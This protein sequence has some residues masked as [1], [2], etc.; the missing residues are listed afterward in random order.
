[1]IAVDTNILVC[2]RREDLPWHNEAEA[3][4]RELAEGLAQWTIP[5]PCLHEFTAIVTPPRIDRPPTPLGLALDQAEAWQ[6]SPSLVILAEA[7]DHWSKLKSLALA[8][9]IAGPQ[10][11]DACIAAL[12]ICHGA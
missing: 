10:I 8:G 9:K 12:C 2:A 6:A 5:W 3:R 11:H 4:V 7:A 1:M